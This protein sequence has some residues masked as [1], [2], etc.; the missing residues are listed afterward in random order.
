MKSELSTFFNPQGVAVIGAS[1]DPHKLGHGVVRNL[2]EY[3]YRG[4]IYPVNP[5]ASQ[6]L[7]HACY[8]SISDVPDP[9]DLAVVIV[10]APSVVDVVDQCGTR[11][12][13]RVIVVSGGFGETGA[14]GK[15]REE[16]LARVARKRGI[17]VIGPNCIGSIDTHTPV[18]TTFV[19]G[20][21][22]VGDIAFVSQSGAMC[23]A[24]IDWAIGAG[25]GFSRIISLGNQVDVNES[26][27]LASLAHDPQTRVI[28]AY[29]EGV[30]D[31]QAFMKAA[32]EAARRKPVVV[33]KGGRSQG[34]A[35]AVTSHT[36]ALAGDAEAYRAAFQHSGLLR[37]STMEELFDWARALAWQP[38]PKGKRVAVLTNAGGPAIMAVDAI[39]TAGLELSP[40]TDETRTYLQPRI[41]VA[42]SVDNPVDILAGSGPGTYAVALDALLSDST[43]D[44]ALVIQAPQDWFLPASL[45]EVIGEVASV[46]QK[47]VL[48]SIMGLASVDQALAILHRRRVPNFAFPE[49]AA[50]VL[51]AMLSRRQWLDTPAELPTVLTD[52]DPEAARTALGRMDFAGVLSAYGIRLPP[53]RLAATADEA[54]AIADEL[55][56]PVVLKL[57]SP[58]IAH[59]SDVGGVVLNLSDRDAVRSSFDRTLKAV[60]ATSPKARIEGMLVQKM[61]ASSHE[62]IVG[63]RRDPQFGP[64]TLVGSGGVD[65]ELQRDVAMGAGR[66]TRSQAE[67]MLDSTRAGIRLKG[68]RGSPPGDRTAVVGIMLRMSQIALDFHEISDLEI[69]PLYVLPDGHGAF[70]VD[71]R[72]S[73]IR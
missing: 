47:P 12:V 62:I 45:A 54:A 17:R 21:P 67:R 52:V 69:N 6:I 20:M 71:V 18:N 22:Q 46:H 32:E 3:R 63:F 28:T 48:A 50:S 73:V 34:G 31:G 2:V 9:V 60:R 65:V 49:R 38:L 27:M 39:E 72:G 59:K 53:S 57:A 7:G 55:G 56:Y 14:K 11:G 33:L 5:A 4:P 68:W 66:L 70:A 40:L 10:P 16:E 15:Q 41:S 23:A 36:G 42:G 61:L 26:E 44:A 1:S 37:A 29:I 25:I 19:V 64:I 24:V 51:A 35:K 58:D 13:K 30:A 8:P 43:V